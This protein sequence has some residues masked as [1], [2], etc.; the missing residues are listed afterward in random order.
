MRFWRQNQVCADWIFEG[1]SG[2]HTGAAERGER[3][4]NKTRAERTACVSTKTRGKDPP[5][6]GEP[7]GQH[8]LGRQEGR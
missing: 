2:A 1:L 4:E 7:L 8:T 5:G 6:E 3:G